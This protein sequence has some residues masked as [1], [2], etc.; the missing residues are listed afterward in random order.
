MLFRKTE[1]ISVMSVHTREKIIFFTGAGISKASGIPTF[2]E[3]PGVRT[4]LTCSYAIEHPDEYRETIRKMMDTCFAA[5]PNA[6]HRSIAELGCPVITM[7][8]DRLHRRAGTERL[9][10]VHG[11]FPT[12]E[13]LEAENFATDYRK[14]VLYGDESPAYADA[15][16]LTRSLIYRDSYFIVV[17]TSFYTGISLDLYRIAKKQRARIAVINEDAVDVVPVICRNLKENR[18]L[19][20]D[21]ENPE[22][23]LPR[24]TE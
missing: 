8:V 19:M 24:E 11:T 14:I 18:A 1:G 2:S 13:E 20:A 23:F 15:F 6:A 21:V 17:G 12:Y 3:M 16:R 5:E 10:E 7:N 4:I 9:I 22:R